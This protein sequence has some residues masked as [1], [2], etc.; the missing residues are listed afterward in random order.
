MANLTKFY[1]K[2]A[3]DTENIVI[4]KNKAIKKKKENILND[5]LIKRAVNRLKEFGYEHDDTL[6]NVL[7]I[8]RRFE[9]NKMKNELRRIQRQ[10]LFSQSKTEAFNLEKLF[11]NDKAKFWDKIKKFRK[12][13]DFSKTKIGINEFAEYYS[14]LFS[15]NDRVSNE[16]QQII[17]EEVKQFYKNVKDEIVPD[18]MFSNDDIEKVISSLKNNKAVG[19]DFISNEML[20]NS[21][22]PEIITILSFIFNQMFKYGYVPSNFNTALVTPIPKKGEQNSPKDFRPISVSTCYAT[23]YEKLIMMKINNNKLISDNQ[24]GYKNHTSCKHAYFLVNETISYYN[25]GRSPMFIVSL[26]VQKAFDKLWRDGL[27]FK[28]KESVDKFIWRAIYFYYKNS[29]IIVKM[30]GMVSEPYKTTEGAKQGGVLSSFL[31]NYFINDMIKNCLEKNIGAKL[32]KINVS[33]VAHC[34]DV[35]LMSPTIKHLQILLNICGDYAEKW[36][37]EFN[38]TKSLFMR[39][40]HNET[41]D[42][43]LKLNQVTLNEVSSMIYLGLPLGDEKFISDFFSK[44]MNKCERSFYSLYG[45]GCRPHSL[46]PSSIAFI[47]KQYCQSIFRSGL[48]MLYI[49][50]SN[51]KAFNIRQSILIKRSIGISKYSKTTPLIEALKIQSIQELYTRHKIYFYKQIQKNELTNDVFNYLKSFYSTQINAPKSSFVNQLEIVDK[52]VN[53]ANCHMKQKATLEKIEK[54]FSLSNQGVIDSIKF[55]FYQFFEN[56]NFVQMKF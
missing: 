11:Q 56:R 25:K 35:I 6:N 37:I 48:D 31:F 4:K 55:I 15:H 47:Y 28:L 26:D 7:N 52:I 21:N 9:W 16:D 46:K 2:C 20:K 3:R 36:K 18:N 29:K 49:N 22:C 13:T 23:I 27:F 24:F 14:D 34:D 32:G 30:D 5:P 50:S 10:M 44:N 17:E 43:K 33:I 39:F 12:K 38:S 51:L 1:I 45:L 53:I 19:Y 8:R 41:I 42:N 54:I 40:A